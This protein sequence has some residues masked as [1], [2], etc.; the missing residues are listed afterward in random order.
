MRKFIKICLSLLVG[1]VLLII[2]AS[3]LIV[4]FVNPARFKDKIAAQVSQSTGLT[5]TIG[6][7]EWS[8]WPY[9][10]LQIQNVVMANP[11]GFPNT[12]FAEIGNAN[13]EVAFT[14]LLAG[15]INITQ[16]ELNQL[17]LNLIKTANGIT[18][19]SNLTTQHSPTAPAT[20][21]TPASTDNSKIKIHDINIKNLIINNAQINW[22]NNAA[23]RFAN[24]QL[25]KFQSSNINLNGTAFPVM[26]TWR[27]TASAMPQPLVIQLNANISANQATKA[28]TISQL[29]ALLNNQVQITGQVQADNNAN[30]PSL[31]MNLQIP[32]SNVAGLLTSIGKPINFADTS[33]LTNVAATIDAVATPTSLQLNNIV[34]QLDGSTIKAQANLPSLQPL[35]GT[36]AANIDTLNV[37]RYQTVNNTPAAATSSVASSTAISSPQTPSWVKQANVNGQVAINT[38]QIDK[39]V[40]QNISTPINLH[41]GIIDLK[42]ASATAYQGNIQATASANFNGNAPAYALNL[43]ISNVAIGDLLKDLYN[44]DRLTGT[45]QVNLTVNASGNDST[46]LLKTATGNGNMVVQNG[47]YNGFNIV[48]ALNTAASLFFKQ[49]PASNSTSNDTPFSIANVVFA[50]NNGVMEASTINLNSPSL[51]VKGDGNTDLITRA[52]DYHLDVEVQKGALPQVAKLQDAIGGSIPLKVAGTI[53]QPQVAPNMQAITLRA[54]KESINS[55]LNDLG[56]ALDKTGKNIGKALN[57]L[58]ND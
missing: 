9:L 53:D 29:K 42:Q 14:G 39:L 40:L 6:N 22:Q 46:T 52:L 44:F 43:A 11:V 45:G 30:A 56:K 31:R 17:H 37:N 55:N 10:H 54:T 51:T 38:L 26:M 3:A 19:W 47:V 50:L 21:T 12:P 34:L 28:Y 15:N 48:N 25:D 41:N 57:N 36:Y 20:T 7:I 5:T 23:N 4:F 13:A 58:F 8:V 32:N 27:Y 16:V 1:L 35:R 18:N 33:A 2:I 49:P 24:L